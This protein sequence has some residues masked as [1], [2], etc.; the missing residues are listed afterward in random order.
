LEQEVAIAVRPSVFSNLA[1]I[2]LRVEKAR[3]ILAQMN[4]SIPAQI[5]D[6]AQ[7]TRFLQDYQPM[8]DAQ[9]IEFMERVQNYLSSG[10][11]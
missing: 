4:I 3:A 1:S 11:M 6:K 9:I 5:A 10:N 8:T 7:L 2:T